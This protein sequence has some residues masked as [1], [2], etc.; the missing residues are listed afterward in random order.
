MLTEQKL[1]VGLRIRMCCRGNG[2]ILVWGFAFSESIVLL[3][4]F[5]F[6]PIAN[7]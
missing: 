7:H 3:I 2:F 4:E 1:Q 5:K 6:S